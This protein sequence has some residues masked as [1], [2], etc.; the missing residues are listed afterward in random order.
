MD[1][2]EQQAET[3]N[4]GAAA[5][6]PTAAK[7]ENQ[8]EQAPLLSVT[9]DESHNSNSAQQ[10]VTT[11]SGRSVP[12]SPL[13]QP[14]G[15]PSQDAQM[16]S[17]SYDE[18]LMNSE[19]SQLLSGS[20]P[21]S[22]QLQLSQQQREGQGRRLVAAV[23]DFSCQRPDGKLLFQNLSFEVHQGEI[24]RAVQP[25]LERDASKLALC[26]LVYRAM[27]LATCCDVSSCMLCILLPA[28]WEVAA[29]LSQ[30]V[31]WWHTAASVLARA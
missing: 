11:S 19:H 27:R 4:I 7:E 23:H 31:I 9:T 3:N 20:A 28:I 22:V 26:T 12:Y 5:A 6:T 13:Q 17:C 10:Q 2:L 16:Q 18:P 15:S 1:R 24:C 14:T 8:E 30:I 29:A 25:Q 21:L